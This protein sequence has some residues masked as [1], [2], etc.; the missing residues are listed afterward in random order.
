MR[1][2]EFVFEVV[3]PKA[4]PEAFR[5]CV[6]GHGRPFLGVGGVCAGVGGGGVEGPFD[7]RAARLG[8]LAWASS[9]GMSFCGVAALP[10]LGK[11]A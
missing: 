5:G 3:A 1:S 8:V 6:V 4:V 10:S 2:G 7:W 11:V 9:G